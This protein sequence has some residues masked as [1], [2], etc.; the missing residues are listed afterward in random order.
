MK[1]CYQVIVMK[2]WYQV[3]VMKYYLKAI[4]TSHAVLGRSMHTFWPYGS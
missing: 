3:I 2:Y 4:L 1:Y